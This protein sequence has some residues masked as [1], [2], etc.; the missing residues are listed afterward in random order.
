MTLQQALETIARH[1]G[2]RT[3]ATAESISAGRIAAQ[4]ATVPGAVDFLRGGL[5][6]YQERIK[7]GLLGVEAASIYSPLAA[8]EMALGAARLLSADVAVATTGVAGGE[9]VDGVPAGTVFVGIA[10]DGNADARAYHFDGAPERVA[11]QAGE[12]ALVDLARALTP[13]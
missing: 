11:E 4:L 8:R 2:S 13:S 7:R 9:P 6:A 5:V 1:V 12:Q 3:I 10:L